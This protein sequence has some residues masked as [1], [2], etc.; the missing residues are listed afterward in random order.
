MKNFFKNDAES[1]RAKNFDRSPGTHGENFCL[2][3]CHTRIR[4]KFLTR[5]E[6]TVANDPTHHTKP[7]PNHKTGPRPFY[8]QKSFPLFYKTFIL[9][10]CA[11]IEIW[12]DI[13]SPLARDAQVRMLILIDR[14][15]VL[16]YTV[17][18]VPAFPLLGVA[19]RFWAPRVYGGSFFVAIC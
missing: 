10:N 19:S 12:G 6:I 7:P 3:R 5:C 14:W 15:H 16:C 2:R 17:S 8:W 13:S 4:E 18:G 9:Y 1:V 11:H